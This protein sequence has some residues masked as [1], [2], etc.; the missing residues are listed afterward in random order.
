[1]HF[2]KYLKA[3]RIF[4]IYSFLLI[5]SIILIF[6]HRFYFDNLNNWLLFSLWLT[7][8]ISSLLFFFISLPKTI[9]ST[10]KTVI[11][12][13]YKY[14]IFIFLVA[15]ATR[16]LLLKSY[17]Y[18]HLGDELRDAGLN[19]LLIFEGR[20]KDVFDL[21]SYQG[22]GNFIPLI[23]ML[24]I[25]LFKNS[26]LMYVIPAALTGI[27][28][29]VFTYVIGR[30]WKGR[31]V[32]LVG[33]LILIGSTYH[34]HYS[35][36]EL[37]II[38]DSLIAVLLILSAY[39]T[40]I[41]QEGYFLAGIVGG[42]SFHLYVGTRGVFFISSSF[43][44]L[45]QIFKSVT[46]ILKNQKKEFSDMLK[47]LVISFSIFLIGFFIGVGPSINKITWFKAGMGSLITTQE[48]FQSKPWEERLTSLIN[49]YEQAFL[50]YIFNPT[51]DPHDSFNKPLLA[52]PLNWFFLGGLFYL[53]MKK[54]D[55]NN[56]LSQLL[57][58]I[59]FLF[60]VSN[61]VLIGSIGV[62]HRLLSVFPFIS[63]VAAFG[64]ISF[65]DKIISAKV[66]KN[67]IITIIIALFLGNQFYFYFFKRPT[68]IRFNL[69]FYKLQNIFEYIKIN[70]N[71]NKFVVL[72]FDGEDNYA[73][74][75]INEPK[76]F[77]TGPK[78]V[79]V[80]FE[81]G[82]FSEELKKNS[83]IGVKNTEFISLYNLPAANGYTKQEIKFD[84][85]NSSLFPNYL[86]PVDFIGK[87][88][89]Y[90]YN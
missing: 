42:F 53:L 29:I 81:V 66:Q 76:D 85:T 90:I 61:Q 56:F 14:L 26:S 12:Q 31:R 67:I 22:Y 52:F 65:V 15:V 13:D 75:E 19:A 82:Q 63:L 17:P 40:Y 44:F 77:Y 4:L 87:Y 6:L 33:A 89:F 2:F 54:R 34:L 62:T 71:F 24:F 48:S 35:R 47:K 69:K 83:Q 51:K 5:D 49:N 38:M 9:I 7:V 41:F 57:I 80:V 59:L 79:D 55:A 60:P 23:S 18:V 78:N 1:M 25:P 45:T 32:A 46:L 16:F 68:D 11:K 28:S 3:G 27:L 20:I 58:V 36:T 88:S 72:L 70:K 21:G 86:C 10:V 84:C 30:I 74:I 39:S 37:L 73:E 64:L 8:L 50:V 43:L